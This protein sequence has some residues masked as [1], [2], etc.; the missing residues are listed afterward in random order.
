MARVSHETWR[1][2]PEV[3][4]FD[5]SQDNVQKDLRVKRSLCLG[6]PRGRM[7]LVTLVGEKEEKRAE[8]PTATGVGHRGEHLQV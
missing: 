4:G 3:G 6:P 5:S 8:Y 2:A 1:R 7:L